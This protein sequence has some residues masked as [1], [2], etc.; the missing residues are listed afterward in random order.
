M[1]TRISWL[2]QLDEGMQQFPAQT[3]LQTARQVQSLGVHQ[4]IPRCAEPC[5]QLRAR[6]SRLEGSVVRYSPII[7]HQKIRRG[8]LPQSQGFGGDATKANTFQAGVAQKGTQHIRPQ[9][10]KIIAHFERKV[11]FI[12]T[13]VNLARV[14][15]LVNLARCQRPPQKQKGASAAIAKAA[16]TSKPY[17]VCH[18]SFAQT[19]VPKA[20]P[21]IRVLRGNLARANPHAPKQGDPS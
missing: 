12:F 9:R 8:F 16:L 7:F 19:F 20:H 14:V 5:V 13:H 21:S 4:P 3:R 18:S 15:V 6:Q 11:L 17:P 1:H 2:H 10:P